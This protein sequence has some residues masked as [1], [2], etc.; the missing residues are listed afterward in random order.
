[1]LRDTSHVTAFASR[2]LI[3]TESAG[4]DP[5]DHFWAWKVWFW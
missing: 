3:S 5:K 2:Q 1:M 4:P